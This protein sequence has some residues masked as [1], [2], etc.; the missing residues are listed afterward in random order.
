VSSLEELDV[1]LESPTKAARRLANKVKELEDVTLPRLDYWNYDACKRHEHPDVYCQWRECG[2]DFW[3]HQRVGVSWLYCVKGGILADETGLGKTVQTL[4]LL[5]L[6]KQRGELGERALIV[7]GQTAAVENTWMRDIRRF[8]PKLMAEAAIGTPSERYA[9]YGGVWDI[10]V[11]GYQTLLRDIE[12]ILSLGIGTIVSDDVDP[13]R[14]LETQTFYEFG[15]LARQP[16][17]ERVVHLNAT[18]LHL[19]LD[20]L[21]TLCAPLGGTEEFGSIKQFQRRYIRTELVQDFHPRS[22]RSRTRLE[23]VGYKNMKEFKEKFGP[24]VLRRKYEDVK[25]VKIPTVAPPKEVWLDLHPPQ[26]QKYEELR[27]GVLRLLHE[28]GED[29]R[30]VDALAKVTYGAMVCAGLPALG[31]EDG[32]GASVKLD[33]LVEKLT[34]DWVDEKVVVFSRFKGTIRALNARLAPKGVGVA[35]FWGDTKGG[36]KKVSAIRRQ[37]ED[38]FWTDPT[39]RVAVG[40]SAIERSLNF[41]VARIVVNFDLL[42]NPQRMVQIL[43]RARRAG[44]PHEHVYPFSLLAHGTQEDHYLDVLEQRAALA[45]F[46]FDDVNVLFKQLSAIEL[47]HLIRA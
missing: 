10:L 18:P 31:E 28:Q 26:R 15:R 13:V 5:A 32:P 16:T 42:L 46:V 25:D 9:R 33:W 37:E 17:T 23:V 8:T 47:L 22:G 45:N 3:E 2:G 1:L 30:H 24:F 20:D 40:T 29:V 34:G 39:C 27:R 4:G 38:R 36:A 11:I 21:Y 44:S 12:S 41:Q 43:G 6:M 7:A 35:L 19:R 14:H